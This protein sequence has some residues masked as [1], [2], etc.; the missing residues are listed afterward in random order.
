MPNEF[1]VVTGGAGMIGSNVTRRLSSIGYKVIVVD[2][3]SDSRKI[4]NISDVEIYEY[5]DRYD[6]LY[7]LKHKNQNKKLFKKIKKAKAVIHNGAISYTT[8]SD[9]NE[10]MKSNYECSKSL[11]YFCKKYNIQ[12]IYASSASVYGNNKETKEIKENENPLNMYAYSKLMFDNFIRRETKY[13][14]KNKSQIVGLRYFNCYGP[15]EAHK[16]NQFSPFYRYFNTIKQNG[17]LTL[18]SGDDGSGMKAEN[19]SRDFVY[20]EDVVNVICWFMANKNKSG[21]YNVGSGQS[22]RFVDVCNL[23]LKELGKDHS[24]IEMLPFPEELKGKCQQY[25]LADLSSL[26]EA[27]YDR[28]M[29]PPDKGCHLYYQQL[30]RTT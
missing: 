16:D 26:R 5:I 29:T 23:A 28:A 6:F 24:N 13:F 25:T 15:G 2:D 14:T 1:I 19:H 12:F 8:E 22:V 21:I 7:L 3:L 11:F 30:T 10:L 4:K 17:K 18:I 20:T 27:G 9:G